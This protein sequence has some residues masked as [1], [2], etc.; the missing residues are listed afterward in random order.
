M[1]DSH[2]SHDSSR[3]DADALERAIVHV[4]SKFGGKGLCYFVL[5]HY[6]DRLVDILTSLISE[7]YE[8]YALGYSTSE[9]SFKEIYQRIKSEAYECLQLDPKNILTPLVYSLDDVLGALYWLYGGKGRRRQRKHFEEILE[10]AHAKILSGSV[11]WGLRDVVIRVLSGIRVYLG[12]VLCVVLG[13]EDFK[14]KGTLNKIAATLHVKVAKY[15]YYARVRPPTYNELANRLLDKEKI[16]S[17]IGYIV[18]AS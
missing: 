16:A 5:H 17:F 1:I 10:R 2:G 11:L 8:S 6:L 7:Y 18:K 9:L 4:R 14:S 15:M 3:Y 13:D 12:C